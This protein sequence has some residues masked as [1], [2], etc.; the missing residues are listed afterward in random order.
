M[1]DTK[2]LVPGIRVPRDMAS[3]S[4]LS[5]EEAL[6]K[7]FDD[8]GLT[9]IKAGLIQK[10]EDK[11]FNLPGMCDGCDEMI[12]LREVYLVAAIEEY[13]RKKGMN[14]I[15]KNN[16]LDC[17]MYRRFGLILPERYGK[18]PHRKVFQ[19]SDESMWADYSRYENRPADA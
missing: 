1:K 18:M 4:K 10:W 12:P 16:G 7:F 13:C 17:Y 9:Q 11:E 3:C 15:K 14:P 8:I 6:D 19:T 2:I 5:L